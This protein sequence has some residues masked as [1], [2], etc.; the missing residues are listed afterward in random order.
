MLIGRCNLIR[1]V[2]CQFFGFS[3]FKIAVV[4]SFCD[5]NG[6]YHFLLIEV[7]KKEEGITKSQVVERVRLLR[8]KG[9]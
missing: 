6:L 4:A 8:S 3:P 1:E 9:V 5:N 7:I 2:N